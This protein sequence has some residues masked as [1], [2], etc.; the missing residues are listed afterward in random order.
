MDSSF[1]KDV[2]K[3]PDNSDLE[4]A[5]GN[6]Y[7]Y[8]MEIRNFVFEKYPSAIEEWHVAVKKFGWGFRIKDKKRAILYLSPGNGYFVVTFVFGPKAAEQI[9]AADISKE[10]KDE[11]KTAKVY[12]EGRV[13]RLDVNDGSKL[14]D[15]KSLVEIKLAN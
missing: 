15:I 9:F 4:L 1:F 12:V 6:N 13:I 5:L 7:R 2:T 14:P 8:W 10:I 3:M 11:L